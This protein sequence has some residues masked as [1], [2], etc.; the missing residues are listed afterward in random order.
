MAD[1]ASK[2]LDPTVSSYWRFELTD[3]LVCQF[4]SD[5]T[6]VM[7]SYETVKTRRGKFPDPTPIRYA[8]VPAAFIGPIPPG[9]EGRYSPADSPG[10]LREDM[11]RASQHPGPCCRSCLDDRDM[12]IDLGEPWCCCQSVAE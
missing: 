12:G 7:V 1:E 2:Y 11:D 3:E 8:M 10:S 6:V 9:T 4:W 5:T